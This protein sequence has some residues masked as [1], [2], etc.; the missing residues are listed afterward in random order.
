MQLLPLIGWGGMIYLIWVLWSDSPNRYFIPTLTFKLLAGLCF[1]ALYSY[2]YQGGDSLTQFGY[3]SQLYHMFNQN[4]S[5]YWTTLWGMNT[6]IVGVEP[7]SSFFIK[8][9]SLVNLLSWNSYWISTLFLSTLSFAAVWSLVMRSTRL[10]G[11]DFRLILVALI[12]FPSIAFWTSGLVKETL[13]YAAMCVVIWSVLPLMSDGSFKWRDILL[14]L[15]SLLT[16]WKLKYYHAGTLLIVLIPMIIYSLIKQRGLSQKKNIAAVLV[17][18][19]MAILVVS[20]LHYNLNLTRLFE[21]IVSNNEIHLAQSTQEKVI[22]Y[23]ELSP[24]LSSMTYNWP[25][26]IFQGL[27]GP[28]LWQSWNMLSF[29]Q[30]IEN[31]ILLMITMISLP[32]MKRLIQRDY[33]TAFLSM[34]YILTLA[35]FLSL[36]TPNYGTLSRYKVAYLPFLLIYIFL[37]LPLNTWA[38]KIRPSKDPD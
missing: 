11:I 31:T 16:L 29:M 28:Q 5:Q 34:I 26:A 18:L 35:S 15:F 10:Y 2:H 4:P 33:M 27:F 20:T 22:H 37:S 7:R 38:K 13:T 23:N 1:G 8:I 21:L 32:Y 30:A 9:V 12:F 25:I 3:S 17:S 6:T 14:G 24:T 19:L 36:S